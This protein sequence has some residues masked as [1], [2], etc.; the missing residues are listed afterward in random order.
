MFLFSHPTDRKAF[1]FRKRSHNLKTILISVSMFITIVLIA[2]AYQMYLIN[3]SE[4]FNDYTEN[5]TSQIVSQDFDNA[6]STLQDLE[7]LWNKNNALLMMFHDHTLIN[8]AS[9]HIS[10][11]INS[12]K[13]K[14][15]NEAVSY[16][17]YFIATI[18]EITAENR[19]TFENIL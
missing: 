1:I 19:P 13:E 11:A 18:E 17:I 10:L 9:V 3:L 7:T 14:R 5:I 12:V 8:N 4:K 15:F 2:I 6:E 16:L